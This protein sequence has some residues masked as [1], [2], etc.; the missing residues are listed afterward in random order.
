MKQH[1]SLVYALCIINTF[2]FGAPKIA[3]KKIE[4]NEYVIGTLASE[5]AHLRQIIGLQ[6]RATSQNRALLILVEQLKTNLSEMSEESE[7][8][9]AIL[10]ENLAYKLE[11]VTT[12]SSQLDTVL[13]NAQE[14]T[15]TAYSAENNIELLVQEL[16]NTTPAPEASA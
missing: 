5:S 2:A 12:L 7:H 13:K 6:K 10:L 11:V 1:L 15:I 8:Q 4:R 16:D 9:T 14:L 3:H